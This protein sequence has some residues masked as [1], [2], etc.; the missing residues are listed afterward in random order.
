MAAVCCIIVWVLPCYPCIV[1]QIARS[2][3]V[4]M[5]CVWEDAIA[6][7]WALERGCVPG[8]STCLPRGPTV[9]A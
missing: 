9:L 1:V 2:F 8:S 3:S 5:G 6:V 7:G 4:G